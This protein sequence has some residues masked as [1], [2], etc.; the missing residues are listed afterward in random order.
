MAQDAIGICN[1]PEEFQ[2]HLHEIIEGVEGVTAIADDLL[3]TGVGDTHK[4]ALADHNRNL[5]VLLERCR[6][7]NFKQKKE[8]LIFKHQKLKYCGYILTTEGILQD[9]AKV[10][11]I[12]Q[13]PRSRFNTEVRRLL[14]MIIWVT[15]Y[16]SCLM[17]L[18]RALRN[19]TK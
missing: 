2:R 14:G 18:N 10:E 11:A 5:N 19:L 17:Y 13:M 7:R 12:T 1:A 4:E 3:V 8:K 16:C 6:K 9:L 15:S